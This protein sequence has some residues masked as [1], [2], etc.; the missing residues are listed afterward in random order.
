MLEFE[1]KSKDNIKLRLSFL[2]DQSQANLKEYIDSYGPLSKGK[3][4]IIELFDELNNKRVT[5]GH[6]YS[7]EMAN[8]M[9]SIASRPRRLIKT[10]PFLEKILENRYGRMV[11][12]IVVY[13]EVRAELGQEIIELARR[14]Y[15]CVYNETEEN[16]FQIFK[17]ELQRKSE[18]EFKDYRIEPLRG[19]NGPYRLWIDSEN[20]LLLYNEP[21][22]LLEYRFYDEKKFHVII[23]MSDRISTMNKDEVYLNLGY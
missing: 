20:S 16:L 3:D 21:W 2:G 11:H 7:E 14:N 17:K 13:W 23:V 15:S 8:I 12:E 5:A 22:S 10:M 6:S 19:N 9:Y 4:D 18:V 1:R